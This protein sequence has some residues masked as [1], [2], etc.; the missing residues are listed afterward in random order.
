MLLPLYWKRDISQSES[1]WFWPLWNMF[2]TQKLWSDTR[3]VLLRIINSC[4]HP[5]IR[6]FLEASF[7]DVR[8]HANTFSESHPIKPN[9]SRCLHS[10]PVQ[11]GPPAAHLRRAL[12]HK[13]LLSLSLYTHVFPQHTDPHLP[14]MSAQCWPQRGTLPP[15]PTAVY[16]IPP[17]QRLKN[18]KN[19]A[20]CGASR[21]LGP[22][23][24]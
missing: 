6:I 18:A 12:S 23:F 14:L 8:L 24:H 11:Q 1:N 10:C 21:G 9:N 13:N 15:S 4:W 2:T 7:T 19:E 16:C 22:G 20:C 17:S 3:Y 5:N